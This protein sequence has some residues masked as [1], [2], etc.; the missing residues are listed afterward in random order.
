MFVFYFNNSFIKAPLLSNEQV[1][2][3]YMPDKTDSSTLLKNINLASLTRN[4]QSVLNKTQTLQ[5]VKIVT[6]KKSLKE[7]LDQEYTSG[8]F[9]GGDGYTFTLEDD[10]SSQAAMGILEYLQGK[11][12]GLQIST[13]GGQSASWRGSNTSFFLNESS[14]N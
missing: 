11:V 2:S 3:F 14:S 12:P 1:S 10:P 9:S 5:E 6:Q 13:S 8:F 7:K 4:E